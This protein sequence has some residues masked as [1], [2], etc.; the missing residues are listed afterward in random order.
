ME[1]IKSGF[2]L[3]SSTEAI[4]TITPEKKI[5]YRDREATME[6]LEQ[7]VCA[8]LVARGEMT[9]RG[10]GRPFDAQNQSEKG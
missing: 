2:F 4:V 9:L 10:V 3:V 1:Q 5:L 7:M 8:W 6:E